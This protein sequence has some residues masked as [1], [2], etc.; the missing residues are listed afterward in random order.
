MIV[1]LTREEVEL[2]AGL[3]SDQL[4]RRQFIDPKMPGVRANAPEIRQG[5]ALVARLRAMVDKPE[6]EK[7]LGRSARIAGRRR[8]PSPEVVK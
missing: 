4:F 2:L 7:Q 5:L 3:A 8:S 1:T 6:S